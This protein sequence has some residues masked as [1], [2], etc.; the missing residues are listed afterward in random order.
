[1]AV[2]RS[3]PSSNSGSFFGMNPWQAGAFGIGGAAGL[4]LLNQDKPDFNNPADAARPY[5]DKVPSTLSPYFQPYIDQG[6]KA[7]NDAQSQYSR[8]TSNPAD[9][10]S[11]IGQGYHQSP[12][13][14]FKLQQAL[15]GS[16]NAAAAGGMLGTPAHQQENAGVEEGLA[17]QDY[18]GWL[19]HVLGL[20]GQGVTGEQHTADTGYNASSDYGTSLSNALM[21]QGMLA[22]RGTEAQ[23]QYNQNESNAESGGLGDVL[24]FAAKV[25]SWL[26]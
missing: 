5:F 1:M 12:G 21:N 20:Y 2:A 3:V 6:Q 19:N 18:E 15:Q 22:E 26:A 4:G 7:G 14:Q 8:M 10:L 9:L 13:F 16:N 17:N 23:N 11:S 24:G 25:G